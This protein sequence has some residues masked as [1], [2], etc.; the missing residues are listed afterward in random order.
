MARVQLGLEV[1]LEHLEDFMGKMRTVKKIV[2]GGDIYVG[3]LK[4]G[5]LVVKVQRTANGQLVKAE[6][7][8]IETQS[9]RQD[10]RKYL[11]P[12]STKAEFEE[13]ANLTAR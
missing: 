7:F 8:D 12:K 4:D 5:K 11:V 10:S 1:P 6:T 2:F 13:F 9:W 3:R